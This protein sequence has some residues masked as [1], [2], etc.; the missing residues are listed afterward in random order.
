MSYDLNHRDRH[1]NNDGDDED[2]D[3]DDNN[4]VYALVPIRC[5]TDMNDGDDDTV[6]NIPTSSTK[7]SIILLR[8]SKSSRRFQNSDTNIQSSSLTESVSSTSTTTTIGKYELLEAIY[9]SCPYYFCSRLKSQSLSLL[10]DNTKDNSNTAYHR[11]TTHHTNTK[12][13]KQSMCDCV[14]CTNLRQW[15]IPSIPSV[16]LR[17]QTLPSPDL[18]VTSTSTTVDPTTT[19]TASAGT[20][21]THSTK[22]ALPVLLYVR[23]VS[24]A[25]KRYLQLLQPSLPS[26]QKD[27]SKEDNNNSD[28]DPS[29][30]PP[31]TAKNPTTTLLLNDD[32][33]MT[34]INPD[35]PSH[36]NSNDKHHDATWMG[37]WYLQNGDVLQFLVVPEHAPVS[38]TS[39]TPS[40]LQFQLR[41]ISR[42]KDNDTKE[43][44]C[45]TNATTIQNHHPEDRNSIS[46]EA[47]MNPISSDICTHN[48][49]SVVSS[50][51]PSFSPSPSSSSTFVL[52]FVPK[53]TDM[54]PTIHLPKLRQ[55]A[56]KRG[57]TVLS[58]FHYSNMMDN[59]N[60]NSTNPTSAISTDTPIHPTHFVVS[61]RVTHLESIATVLG[62]PNMEEMSL[63]LHKH[64][65]V[66]VT[67]DWAAGACSRP[68]ETPTLLQIIPGFSANHH[69]KRKLQKSNENDPIASDRTISLEE[70]RNR[71]RPLSD[72]FRKLAKLHQDCPLYANDDWKAY[73]FQLISG[74]IL[75][76]DFVVTIND[77]DRL[78]RMNGFGA[79]TMQ[80][81]QEF[82]ETGICR[83]IVEFENDSQRKAMNVMMHIWGVG[84]VRA[85]ELV[86]A[87]YRRIGD[88]KQAVMNGT[89]HLDRNQ[90][91]GLVCYDD[92]NER[93]P[94]TEVEAIAEIVTSFVQNRYTT[95]A[96]TIIMGSYRR[97][98]ETCGD[99]D[100]LI[101]HPDFIDTVPSHALGE[102]VDDLCAAGHVAFHLTYISGMKPNLYETLPI[103]VAKQLT[104]P[105]SYGRSNE[106]KDKFSM[107]SWMG[108]MN[109][110]L[111]PGKRRRVDIKFYPY[112]ERYFA[113]LYFTGNGH[114]NRSMRLY[115]SRKYNYMLSDHGL[116][117]KNTELPIIHH[118]TS[119]R[120]IF[121][122]LGLQWKETNERECF[123]DVEPFDEAIVDGTT[124]SVDR[125]R[126]PELTREE[127]VRDGT[128]HIWID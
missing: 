98:K 40:P 25:T 63:Y 71:N 125:S 23:R 24:Y 93:M 37:P 103:H 114:F 50:S 4:F 7:H 92:I 95:F 61:T 48:N 69:K 5:S 21:T 101:T 39:S 3:V 118:P 6:S 78:S 9:H 115:A 26:P 119:E 126:R 96:E 116:I 62:F 31:S 94:R 46:N 99:V 68:Y 127:V 84:R 86:T 100:I 12:D 120:D 59:K 58:I 85:T 74:R 121:D 105:K 110:P 112:S 76:L 42:H 27:D 41:R 43:D 77:I 88:V 32:P 75:H 52:Y 108:V 15:V 55:N 107:S 18:N 44:I 20:T 57:A 14:T 56:I 65:I 19:T 73:M 109:S 72:V 47:M 83:R 106:K 89:L 51:S 66:C 1:N 70:I 17:F 111:V 16:L 117:D 81:I 123:D 53:G 34:T 64:R 8:S 28:D 90:Y 87:G 54:H 30:T 82:L 113:S 128:E 45:T 10:F 80:I 97:G 124:E 33:Y 79:S 122:V 36:F 13:P 35:N 11:I 104:H 22:D 49:N 102:I 29:I 91:I 2:D 38:S 60:V 67:R